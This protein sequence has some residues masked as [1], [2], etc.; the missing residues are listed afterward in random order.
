MN[1]SD[2][3][4]HFKPR[5]W[6]YFQ[7]TSPW[8]GTSWLGNWPLD[9]GQLCLHGLTSFGNFPNTPWRIP[10][11]PNPLIAPQC[12]IRLERVYQLDC[13]RCQC[14]PTWWQLPFTTFHRYLD[15]TMSPFGPR[16]CYHH[17]WCWRRLL[18]IS[19]RHFAQLVICIILAA[20]WCWG[21][22]RR[23]QCNLRGE[24]R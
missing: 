10:I 15:R 9:P 8:G 5:L 13:T 20:G 4:E 1:P 19:S 11:H 3:L 2:F 23:L 6:N 17:H 16:R 22:V 7:H 12:Y 21:R 14:R 18:F 24:A